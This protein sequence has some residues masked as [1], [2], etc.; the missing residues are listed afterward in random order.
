[1]SRNLL[2]DKINWLTFLGN[3]LFY[4]H[5][6]FS[7]LFSSSHSSLIVTPLFHFLALPATYFILLISFHFLTICYS[8]NN[9]LQVSHGVSSKEGFCL[10][11]TC[12]H[13]CVV[14]LS[15]LISVSSLLH[16]HLT[17]L[18]G[19]WYITPLSCLFI[20]LPFVLFLT[21]SNILFR[22]LP[23]FLYTS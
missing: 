5:F 18:H 12:H 19:I 21:M 9:L 6:L 17:F 11:S 16:I 22:P 13:P 1:M 23:Y 10:V 14:Y 2:K 4:T 15:F 3:T 7:S 8:I 20:L